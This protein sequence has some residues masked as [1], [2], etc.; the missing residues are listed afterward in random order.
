MYY[1]AQLPNDVNIANDID[2]AERLIQQYGIAVIPGTFCGA[3]G[4]IR[5][6]YANL[7]PDQC[8]IAAQRLQH[9]LQSMFGTTSTVTATSR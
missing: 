6:C 2:V 9:G 3:P 4:W 5:I 1:M 8:T 7:P